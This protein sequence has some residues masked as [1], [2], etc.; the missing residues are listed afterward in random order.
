[1]LE[2]SATLF[3]NIARWFILSAVAQAQLVTDGL[4]SYWSFDKADIKGD[5]VRDAWGKNHGKTV[6]NPKSVAGNGADEANNRKP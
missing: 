4:V 5:E 2:K 6:G 1:M 3:L